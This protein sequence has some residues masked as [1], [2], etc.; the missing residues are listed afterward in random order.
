[1]RKRETRIHLSMYLPSGNTVTGSSSDM[2][3]TTI[4]EEVEDQSQTKR[5]NPGKMDKGPFSSCIASRTYHSSKLRSE[6]GSRDGGKIAEEAKA[7]GNCSD[8]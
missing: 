7:E 5:E 2:N 4:Q 6:C 3:T 8:T 1:M